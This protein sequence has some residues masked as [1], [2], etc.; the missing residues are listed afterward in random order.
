MWNIVVTEL[1][2]ANKL[3]PNSAPPG[4]FFVSTERFA[5]TV[6]YLDLS[7]LIGVIDGMQ[8]PRRSMRRKKLGPFRSQTAP[9]V[10]G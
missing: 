5:R 2:D 3:D 10:V 7:K 4:A 8:P 9:A 6:D 1:Q